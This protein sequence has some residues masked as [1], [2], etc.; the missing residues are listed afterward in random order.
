MCKSGVPYTLG[1]ERRIAV[2]DSPGTYMRITDD[3]R[4]TVVFLGYREGVDGITC[5]GTGFLVAYEGAGYLVTARHVSFQLGSDPFLVRLNR[6]DG[7]SENVHCDDFGWVSHPDPTVDISIVPL[8]IRGDS[9]FFCRYMRADHIV[10]SQQQLKDENIGIGN[11]TYTVGL[12][13]LLSGEKRNMPICH[14]G[15][16]AMMPED[17]RIPVLDWTDPKLERRITVEGYL[18]E[19]QSLSGLSGSPV[20]VRPSRNLDVSGVFSPKKVDPILA[21]KGKQPEISAELNDMYLLGVWQGAW[22][23]PPDEVMAAETNQTVVPVGMG[24]VVPAHRIIEIMELPD[25]KA[26]R[27]KFLEKYRTPAASPQS[28]PR[29]AALADAGLA[30]D[31]NPTHRVGFNSL[32]SAAAQKQKQDD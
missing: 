7:G 2:F 16:I 19:S 8:H 13:R 11:L 4:N 18:V 6:R 29:P 22:Q 5:V 30:T 20:F 21:R 9:G 17:E 26:N 23:A 14:F 10:L 27:E 3:V 32:L 24:I 28:V 15:T 25:V 12:F 1:P 31:E